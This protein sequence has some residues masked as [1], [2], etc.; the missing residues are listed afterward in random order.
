MQAQLVKWTL[1][2]LAGTA[3]V[4]APVT[5]MSVSRGKKNHAA[6]DEA[7]A[8][9][10]QATLPYRF[11]YSFLFTDIP[12]EDLAI[13]QQSANPRELKRGEVLFRQGGIPRGVYWVTSGKAKIYQEAPDGQHQTLYI[14]SDGDLI[15]YRQLI[16]QEKHPVSAA[17]LENSVVGF[18]PERTFR[19][20]L[21]DSPV[22]ARSMLN[23]LARDFSVWTHRMTVFAQYPVRRRLILALLILY[24][25]YRLSGYEQ[26]VITITRTDLAEFVG[27]SLETVVRVLNAL[28][29]LELVSVRGRRIVL[30]D[31]LKLLQ[32]LEEEEM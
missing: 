10:A 1:H 26:G 23:A 29:S 31:P 16:A 22:F 19:G 9:I 30:P 3:A 12:G 28:K 24:E 13:L 18:I 27:A 5:I 21:N 20:L 25:Q 7:H 8:R 14:Y 15:A 2:T 17:L 11:Q 4:S 6:D 32:V